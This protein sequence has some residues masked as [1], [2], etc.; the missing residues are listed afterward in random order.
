MT[1]T[2]LDD[3][4]TDQ[5][6]LEG[7]NHATRWHYLAMIQFCSRDSRHDGTM[8]RGDASRC[9]DVDDPVAAVDALIAAGLVQECKPGSVRLPRI[10]EH[11][12][13]PYLRDEQRKERQRT[14]KRRSQLH[15]VNDHSEC[16]PD[17]CPH[18]VRP[19]ISTD[20][21]TDTGT[22]RDGPGERYQ[23]LMPR[24][25]SAAGARSRTVDRQA[26]RRDALWGRGGTTNSKTM[27]RGAPLAT[28]PR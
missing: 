21:S 26:Q 5:H 13:P 6:V 2:R 7:L 17:R 18:A 8:R 20:V 4:W 16:L 23:A 19:D 14:E 27:M 3:C 22:G 1:W 28:S 12:P 24:A 10:E 25:M 9:S 11:I 15:R